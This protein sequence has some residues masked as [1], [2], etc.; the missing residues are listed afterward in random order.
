MQMQNVHIPALPVRS[1]FLQPLL[2][3]YLIADTTTIPLVA[4]SGGNIKMPEVD[5][6]ASGNI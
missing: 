5:D 2:R 1:V 3:G 4:A 6:P